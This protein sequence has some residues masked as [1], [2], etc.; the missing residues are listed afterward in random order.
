MYINL[1]KYLSDG[2]VHQVLGCTSI[3][4]SSAQSRAEVVE[5]FTNLEEKTN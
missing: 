2:I 3:R 1:G 5:D 4:K